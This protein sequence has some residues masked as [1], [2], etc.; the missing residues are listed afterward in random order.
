MSNH[1]FVVLTPPT[2]LT[3]VSFERP[4]QFYSVPASSAQPLYR[5]VNRFLETFLKDDVVSATFLYQIRT[6]AT[7]GDAECQAAHAIATTTLERPIAAHLALTT[8]AGICKY[9]V[10]LRDALDTLAPQKQKRRLSASALLGL[11]PF[12]V[13]LQDYFEKYV[14]LQI[15]LD[16]IL[17]LLY[18][19]REGLLHDNA[20]LENEM[21]RSQTIAPKLRILIE[22]CDM[23]SYELEPHFSYLDESEP[24]RAKILREDVLAT[25]FRRRIAIAAQLSICQHNINIFHCVKQNNLELIRGIEYTTSMT[26]KTLHIA[27]Q[28]AT[29][30]TGQPFSLHHISA[31]SSLK[32]PAVHKPSPDIQTHLDMLQTAFA[33]MYDALDV[34][35]SYRLSTRESFKQTIEHFQF[36]IE[37]AQRRGAMTL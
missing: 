1:E 17:K 23:L 24:E 6:L 8:Q 34:F 32:A 12:T 21:M 4:E 14:S 26:L 36:T 35:E 9:L 37:E 31:L 25:I 20:Q 5:Q 19:G 29:A 10:E 2:A 15:R 33:H 22:L 18:R 28:A 27:I 11:N 30:I 16:I 7:L 3:G 13:R